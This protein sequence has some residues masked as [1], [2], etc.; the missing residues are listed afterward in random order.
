MEEERR[1][2]LLTLER[3]AKRRKA[4]AA[5]AEMRERAER[6]ESVIR[7]NANNADVG[8]LTRS[9]VAK[10]GVLRSAKMK[11]SGKSNQCQATEEIESKNEN[12]R[13]KIE[14]IE[15]KITI[16]QSAQAQKKEE[17]FPL[18]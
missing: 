17:D 10:G 9:K 7:R 3:K 11:L 2:A 5:L 4:E 16:E 1:Q 12:L 6:N 15:S 14:D 18:I 13:S 8:V